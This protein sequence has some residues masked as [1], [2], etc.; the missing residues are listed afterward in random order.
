MV[1][2]PFSD[3]SQAK[4]RPAVALANAGRDDWILC[5]VTTSAY[6]D[7]SAIELTAAKLAQFAP[8]EKLCTAGQAFHGEP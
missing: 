8:F 1:L 3:L 7:A 4:L 6:G 2:V 5:Q